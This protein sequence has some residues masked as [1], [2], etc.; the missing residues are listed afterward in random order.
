MNRMFTLCLI[1]MAFGAVQAQEKDTTYWK[2]GGIASL[3]FTNSDQSRYWQAGGIASQS[4]VGRIN[5]FGNYEKAKTSW[6]NDLTLGLG[7]VR[8]GKGDETRFIK[9]EDRIILN[10]KFGHRFSP[11]LLLSGLFSFRT[12][13][14]EGYAFAPNQPTVTPSDTVSNFLAPGYIE[15]GLG[16]D[17]QPAENISIYYSPVNSKVTIV[18]LDEYRPLYI[19]Q[20][21]TTGPVRYEI[22]SKLNIKY[23]RELA[24]NINFQTAAGFFANYLQNFGNIDVN[25]ETLTTAKVNNWLAINFA[26]NL[27]YD[28][29][30]RFD[31]VDDNG[32]STGVKGP[33]TQFQH[34]LSIGLTYTFLK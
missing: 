7:A 23:R 26:T 18:T 29:D 24:K 6:Q 5:V 10:S 3:G 30:V 32:V 9:N 28:D 8:Q 20:D 19:P 2:K 15:F 33:R 17:W 13:F 1:L 21:I 12:Q 25:W 22:G 34:V 27:I 11:K 31:I 16:L 4:I 14:I